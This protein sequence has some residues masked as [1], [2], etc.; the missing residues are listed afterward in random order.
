MHK[1][2]SSLTNTPPPSIE[3]KK[4]LLGRS[5]DPKQFKKELKLTRLQKEV[6]PGILLGDAHLST[7]DNGKSYRLHINQGIKHKEYVY[8]LYDIF[9]EFCLLEPVIKERTH[10]TGVCSG[11]TYH[12]IA[13]KTVSTS[14]FKFFGRLFNCNLETKTDSSKRVPRDISR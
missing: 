4:R 13:F 3:G 5:K 8:H 11:K 6:L 9:K 10:K 14:L 2:F 12:T 1:P 7:Q